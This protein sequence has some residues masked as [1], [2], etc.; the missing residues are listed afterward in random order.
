MKRRFDSLRSSSSPTDNEIESDR[1]YDQREINVLCEI[2]ITD[3]MFAKIRLIEVICFGVRVWQRTVL[4]KTPKIW[5][6]KR[7]QPWR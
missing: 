2:D 1:L 7:L 5:P 3:K 6:E 4:W